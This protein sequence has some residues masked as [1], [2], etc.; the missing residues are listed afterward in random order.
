[1]AVALHCE[2]PDARKPVDV[3]PSAMLNS[4]SGSHI[5]VATGRTIA[6]CVL[7]LALFLL[8]CYFCQFVWWLDPFSFTSVS[9]VMLCVSAVPGTALAF[10]C[11]SW[12]GSGT[13]L[14]V[15]SGDQAEAGPAS[16]LPRTKPKRI[17][18]IASLVILELGV[19]AA[20]G[21]AVRV[22]TTS[23]DVRNVGFVLVA[24]VVILD[25][26]VWLVW[27][28]G[29]VT[30][31]AQTALLMVAARA[32]ACVWGDDYWLLGHSG[33]FLAMVVLLAHM[34]VDSMIPA[35][36]SPKVRRQRAAADMLE[37]LHASMAA[38]SGSGDHAIPV[39][40]AAP[41]IAKW[42]QWLPPSVLLGIMCLF[43]GEVALVTLRFEEPEVSWCNTCEARPQQYY[44]GVALGAGLVYAVSLYGLRRSQLQAFGKKGPLLETAPL[45]LVVPYLCWVGVAAYTSWVA[46]SWAVLVHVSLL[47]LILGLFFSAHH[48]W[49]V[50]DFHLTP[51]PPG[52]A[53]IAP[54]PSAGGTAGE[55]ASDGGTAAADPAD[56]ASSGPA[57]GSSSSLGED[58][59]SCLGRV[60]WTVRIWLMALLLDIAYGVILHLVSEIRFRWV[61]WSIS[62]GVLVLALTF[63]SNQ[64]WFGTFQ[65]YPEQPIFW[66]FIALILLAWAGGVWY[67][68]NDMKVD[69]FAMVLLCVVVLY[70]AVYVAILAVQVLRDAKWSPKDASTFRFVRNALI[71]STVVYLAF[72]G[73]LALLN[74]AAALGGFCLLLMAAIIGLAFWK[75]LR[76][77]RY[78]SYRVKLASAIAVAFCVLGS[79][80]GITFYFQSIFGG[81]TTVCVGL[82]LL[83]AG[84]AASEVSDAQSRTALEQ[85]RVESSN[86]VFPM[87]RF[88]GGELARAHFDI[89]ST[90]QALG[91]IS[92][93]GLVAAVVLDE[94]PALGMVV[95]VL[96]LMAILILW[97]HLVARGGQR[98][99]LVLEQLP[100]AQ[101][102]AAA[103][104]A[105]DG[106]TGSNPYNG[107]QC[108]KRKL[109]PGLEHML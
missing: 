60:P 100:Q 77:N 63:M 5:P 2:R 64:M 81:F 70:P 1:M 54:E 34:V 74:W 12:Q 8:G 27:A 26:I 84:A 99:A 32:A 19:L 20:Y 86:F 94:L 40:L 103:K 50:D 15:L 75:W 18:L 42:K 17:A 23:D 33:V 73:A 39:T 59:P 72:L 11:G 66:G 95:G 96:A 105:L 109:H 56:P 43:A 3:D 35:P 7:Q 104:E 25:S 30:G 47:P 89:S 57:G 29:L 51:R 24:A 58:K 67:F 97:A 98:R 53:K 79:A 6:R 80:V 107:L 41:V 52:T 36:D 22:L 65:L 92:V 69:N 68:E 91:V 62:G 88:R 13:L 87:F 45:G 55:P 21:L 44:A 85:L 76:N 14:A 38:G 9:V 93:W 106:G 61:G 28:L 10:L 48:R 78:I 90:M 108:G 37:T 16:A 31:A 83:L 4:S 102:L 71:F 49:V 101:L 82:T 46:D